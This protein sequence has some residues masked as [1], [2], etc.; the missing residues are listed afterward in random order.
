MPLRPALSACIQARACRSRSPRLQCPLAWQRHDIKVMLVAARRLGV[1]M[2]IGSAGDTGTNSRVDRY[3]DIVQ[4]LAKQH[5]I[6][7]FRLGYFYSEVSKEAVRAHLDNR[8]PVRGLDGRPDLTVE[9]LDATDRMV[10]VA[11]VHHYMQLLDMGADV[12]I[13][14]A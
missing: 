11:G 3:V 4:E 14:G 10:A 1:P 6:P 12:V 2:M 7:R 5:R 9:E 8:E 13:G